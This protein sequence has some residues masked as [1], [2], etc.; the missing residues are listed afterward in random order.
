MRM[1]LAVRRW[2]FQ[3]SFSPLFWAFPLFFS[4]APYHRGARAADGKWATI[5]SALCCAKRERDHSVSHVPSFI[6]PLPLA[7]PLLCS[8]FYSSLNAR[9]SSVLMTHPVEGAE[10]GRLEDIVAWLAASPLGA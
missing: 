6:P 4:P 7:F 9:P 5:W 1:V 3:P 2:N 8:L 10:A